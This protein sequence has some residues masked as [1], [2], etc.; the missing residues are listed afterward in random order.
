MR[1]VAAAWTVVCFAVLC[2]GCATNPWSR[3]QSN[4]LID[5]TDA[6]RLGYASGW[7][8]SINLRGKQQIRSAAV[9]DD[10]IVFVEG[11]D[12][13]VTAL[14]ARDGSLKWR[15]LIDDPAIV[16]YGPY[17]VGNEVFVN[18]ETQ[19]FKIDAEKG[20]LLEIQRLDHPVR[21][22]G[23]VAGDLV[24]FGAA[25]GRVFAHQIAAGY[26]KWKY[27]LTSQIRV[28]P[29]MT[30]VDCF[31]AD[32][33]GVYAMIEASSGTLSFRGRTLGAVNGQPTVNR[34]SVLLPCDDGSLYA[35]D[36]STG[37]DQWIYRARQP[38]RTEPVAID[39]QVF[40]LVDAGTIAIDA[41]NGKQLW[42]RP[43]RAKPLLR[44]DDRLL[45][46]L[47]N[48]LALAELDTGDTIDQAATA[49]LR[50][51]L[52]NTDQSAIFLVSTR[53]DVQQLTA[54]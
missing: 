24:I 27:A 19:F 23:A 47:G 16:L 1:Q 26:A 28:S 14:S 46:S 33:S 38:L 2:G 48:G 17:R 43:D 35:L 49:P 20:K 9:L 32:S 5:A 44:R 34:F 21:D 10:L 39:A 42:V 25:N 41:Q 53:G 12:P 6:Q 4:L 7:A 50:S 22:R 13:F 11:P 54:R 8:S 15:R 31:A 45:L 29:V 51:V 18:S 30:T 3:G 36:R 40:L 37:R 52:T